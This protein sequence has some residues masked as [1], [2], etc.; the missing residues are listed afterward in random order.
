MT[1]LRARFLE[2]MSRAANTVNVVTTDGAAG[3]AGVTVSAM[4]SVS[5][6]TEKPTLLVC[7]HH[8][9]PTAQSIAENGV[10]CVNVLRDDQSYVSDIFAGRFRDEVADKFDCAAW[11]AA[12]T[13]SPRVVDPLVAFDCRLTRDERVGTH[14]VFFGEVED[15][16]LGPAGTALV[17]ANR[18]YAATQ[19][20]DPVGSVAAG[21]RREGRTLKVGCFHTFGPSLLPEV[22]SRLTAGTDLDLRLIEGDHRRMLASLRSGESDVALVYDFDLGEDIAAETLASVHP[23]ALLPEGH[24]LAA[25]EAVTLAEL[26]DEPLVLL[27]APP[28]AE[29]FLSLF[30][31]A[32]LEPAV[33][34][35]SGSFEMV[36]GLVGRGLGYSV[37]A[38]RPAASVSHDGSPLAVRAIADKVCP[39][40]IVLA[41]RRDA[42]VSAAAEEFARLC[43]DCID[44][45]ALA[46]E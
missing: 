39:S 19:R 18:G 11:V 3:R 46:A 33:A 15:A 23:H 35:R 22:I 36:R 21:R 17:H 10:F 28:S 32:G 34:W 8:L 16:Y 20:I 6:D 5:A 38:T 7:V 45:R 27:D 29:Y 37:L 41:R 31:E 13:G 1:E 43:R 40:R 9:S 26:A 4:A 2:A 44:P 42:P 25:K 14:H 24:P 12:P 30:S